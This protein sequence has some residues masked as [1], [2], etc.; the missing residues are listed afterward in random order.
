MARGMGEE[1][2][3]VH[4]Q[5]CPRSKSPHARQ[6]IPNAITPRPYTRLPKAIVVFSA[7]MT[8]PPFLSSLP[9]HHFIWYSIQ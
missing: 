7:V 3:P 5:D 6:T 8:F 9:P 1:H 2:R 4:Q